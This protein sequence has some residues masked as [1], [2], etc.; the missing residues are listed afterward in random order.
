M[1]DKH[2]S[3]ACADVMKDPL[4]GS[5]KS[6]VSDSSSS[7]WDKPVVVAE[8]HHDN[9]EAAGASDSSLTL[10]P[11]LRRYPTFVPL[12][13]H[14][15]SIA[16]VAFLVPSVSSSTRKASVLAA[17]FNMTA[18]IVGGGVLSIPLSCA[19]AGILPFTFL[20]VLSAVATDFSLYLLVSC[21]RRCGSTSFGLVCRSSFGSALEIFATFVICILVAFI[22]VGLMI[23]NMGIWSPILVPG[24]ASIRGKIAPDET[25]TSEDAVVLLV[26]LGLMM[27]FLLKKDLTSLCHICYVGFFSI[28]ILCGAMCYRAGEKIMLDPHFV[29]QNI[30]WTATSFADVLN[31]LPIILLAFLS[32]FN[33]ISV[34]CSLVDPTRRRVKEVIHMAVFLSF[35]LMYLFGLAGYLYAYDETNGNILLNFDRK[36]GIILLGRIGCGVTTLFALPMNALPCREALLSW[37]A[38]I[39]ESRARRAATKEERKQLLERRSGNEYKYIAK[40]FRKSRTMPSERGNACTTNDADEE[41][42]HNKASNYGAND[43]LVHQQVDQRMIGSPIAKSPE[44]VM[45]EEAVHRLATFSIVF[46]CYVAAVQAPGVAIVWDIAGSCLA[47]LI[48][49]ILPASCYIRLKLRAKASPMSRHL[50]LAQVLLCFATITAVLCTAQTIWRLGSKW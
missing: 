13:R 32:S 21:A 18:T 33:M 38:Q 28:S 48:Q 45:S 8:A 11:M 10:S 36:D 44:A 49:F 20:M 47:F 19:R 1:R 43:V 42:G 5:R 24:F 3:S 46:V 34:H 16:E 40:S 4:D 39:S 9:N 12:R 29:Q 31:A 37:V 14:A 23:L 26:L 30:K 35:L 41:I 27:P 2:N 50:V 6:A 22:V 7:I 25:T 17:T 15:T